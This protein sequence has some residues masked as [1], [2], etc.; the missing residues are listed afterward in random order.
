M[1]ANHHCDVC[2][3]MKGFP[4]NF[5]LSFFT[6]PRS[7]LNGWSSQRIKKN[8]LIKFQFQNQFEKIDDQNDKH[9]MEESK[10]E[11]SSKQNENKNENQSICLAT[12]ANY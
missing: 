1:V 6:V 4:P 2:Q 11:K 8:A 5:F 12:I 3:C 9:E 10:I 7:W